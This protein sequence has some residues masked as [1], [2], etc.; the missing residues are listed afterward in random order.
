MADML[1]G[2]A[3]AY[4]PWARQGL[5]A[6]LSAPG[7]T[8]VNGRLQL[9]A[10][11]NLT[12]HQADGTL[13]RTTAIAAPALQLQGPVDVAGIDSAQ[14]I[15]MEP[16]PLTTA[17]EPNYFPAIEFD[18]PDLPWLFSPTGPDDQGRCQPWITLVV[19]PKSQAQLTPA[20]EKVLASV[21]CPRAELP[22]LDE[23]WAWAHVQ[24]VS[25][26][27][28]TPI[29]ELL[30]DGPRALSRLICARRLDP[31]TAYWAC[32][33]PTYELGRLAGLGSQLKAADLARWGLQP[34]W[35]SE[36]PDALVH[37]PVYHH[38]S[39]ETG[40]QGDFE[41]L[42]RRLQPRQVPEEAG[43]LA[44][45]AT[46]P[47][48]GINTA[49]GG[50][51]AVPGVLTVKDRAVPAAAQSPDLTAALTQVLNAPNQ[52]VDGLIGPPLYGQ[53]YARLNTLDPA[54]AGRQ[55]P[56]WMSQ[57]NLQVE[58]RI[59]AGLGAL[60]V[61]IEQDAM[62]AAAWDQLAEFDRR[63]QQAMRQQL[64]REVGGALA[65]RPDQVSVAQLG[66]LAQPTRSRLGRPGLALS[67]RR[68]LA[69]ALAA[70]APIKVSATSAAVRAAGVAVRPATASPPAST[71]GSPLTASVASSPSN[72]EP[73][74][75]TPSFLTPAGELLKDFFPAFLFPGMAALPAD[76]VTVLTP[77]QAFVE[78]FM[79]GLNH[80]MGREMQW[81]GFPV[82]L[83]GTSFQHF[84]P[85]LPNSVGSA[86]L[87][88]A[89]GAAQVAARPPADIKEIAA[90]SDADRLGAN[91]PAGAQPS[92]LTVVLLKGELIRRL[93]RVPI[94]LQRAAW[95]GQDRVLGT[96]IKTPVF[97]M[98]QAPDVTL[99]AFDRPTAE[100]GGD[101]AP[102]GDPGWFIVL[103]ELPG[104]PRFG[105]DAVSD[106]FT[107]PW[108]GAPSNWANVNWSHAAAD[109]GALAALTYLP[110]ASIAA[111]SLPL[112]D[113]LGASSP[114]P[115]ATWARSS[116]DIAAITRQRPF[117]LYL[118]G[119]N[120][121][122]PQPAPAVQS[123][124]TTDAA[125]ADDAV[126]TLT[127]VSSAM[128]DL[129]P[130]RLT[131][132]SQHE[133]PV[134]VWQANPA[135]AAWHLQKD[136]LHAAV[137]QASEDIKAPAQAVLDAQAAVSAHE[138]LEP[139]R[140]ELGDRGKPVP[141]PEHGI[142]A[143]EMMVLR[144]AVSQR[145]A[146]LQPW[147][148][149][150]NK[151]VSDEG[152]F[153]QQGPPDQV[154]V[155]NPEHAVW[156]QRVSQA[157]AELAAVRWDTLYDSDTAAPQQD[158]Q[159][160]QARLNAVQAQLAAL[161]AELARQQA[162]VTPLTSAVADSEAQLAAAAMAHTNA[163]TGFNLARD[164]WQA[165]VN[166]EPAM[167]ITADN[168]DFAPWQ[169]QMA[170]LDTAI[171]NARQNLQGPQQALDDAQDALDAEAAIEP[172]PT[173]INIKGLEIT[174][175]EHTAW[176]KAMAKLQSTLQSAKDAARPLQ[177][178]LADLASA[179]GGLAAMQ[180]PSQV[181]VAN[182]DHATWSGEMAQQ[183]ANLGAAQTR[184]D[185]AS[186]DEETARNRL[187]VAQ[188]ALQSTLAAVASLPGQ[189]SA[190]EASLPSLQTAIEH[191]AAALAAAGQRRAVLLG[192]AAPDEVVTTVL[193]DLFK[194]WSDS[195]VALHA[196]ADAAA[197]ADDQLWRLLRQIDELTH[198][199]AQAD[200]DTQALQD[201]LAAYNAAKTALGQRRPPSP[202]KP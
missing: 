90:W 148:H 53:A 170:D 130:Q 11:L 115:S 140:T 71:L 126:R 121:F 70:A 158:L 20:G 198:T 16:A 152:N 197:L 23:A 80:E 172:E 150:L 102:P 146:A 36:A 85:S 30:A 199:I 82:D 5:A 105:L 117:R 155:D 79:V 119:A 124:P 97:Q 77:N 141:N 113:P 57:L 67:K 190:L 45:D 12:Q 187:G 59:A 95:Q 134:L 165:V 40:E 106:G 184:L 31:G 60:V 138:A 132:L 22:A 8:S 185:S 144:E 200:H 41:S 32:V 46:H 91:A 63:N 160:A 100:L 101:A 94:H 181:T 153:D 66:A 58:H 37:L 84:W 65:A 157:R 89:V 81:R 34:A 69:P 49:S 88:Q 6:D 64:A 86:A 195:E 68:S 43:T 13:T 42:A 179:R 76:S 4:L 145:Q 14:V 28:A 139:D 127:P 74:T 107:G 29:P 122:P 50:T 9:P 168:P 26:D 174:N 103:Q 73:Q 47:G 93:P 201:A 33:V 191:A 123:G 35:G 7:V 147:Q 192:Q 75:F 52:V 173:I 62:M 18:R 56:A 171:G 149:A 48:W 78:A 83:R 109:A 135:N 193:D 112:S 2:L 114:P 116:A 110:L 1:G 156:A 38:W 98:D 142:W 133:P 120:W 180:P 194:R 111:Q 128:P 177:Q 99:L 24:V 169:R 44:V 163:E 54:Q 178:N 25:G 176:A 189:I 137:V 15:R 104:E 143:E 196:L 129:S 159:A 39:F 161:R 154:V 72:D 131:T 96:E 61:R 136:R 92:A 164:A 125:L 19:L 186:T 202:P 87:A 118:H 167:T 188:A 108:G 17:F 10:K 55:P 51:L 182:P 175:P 27:V 151:A 162:L 183:D 166:R 3:T 21:S